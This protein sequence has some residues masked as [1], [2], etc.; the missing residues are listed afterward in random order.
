[1]GIKT[2]SEFFSNQSNFEGFAKNQ[3]NQIKWPCLGV[4]GNEVIGWAI[5]IRSGSCIGTLML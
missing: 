4:P 1:M 5:W 3:L 2:H